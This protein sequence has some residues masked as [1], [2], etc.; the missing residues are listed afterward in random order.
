MTAVTA[1]AW[2]MF[3]VWMFLLLCRGHFWRAGV[4]DDDI[5]PPPPG[6]WPAVTAVI[7]ARDEAD[8]IDATLTSLFAQDYKGSLQIIVVDDQSSDG[9]SDIAR[10]AAAGAGATDR[11]LVLPGAPL[12]EGW[13]GKLWAVNQGI[14]K[15]SR[16]DS[17]PTFIW[18]SDADI[19]YA[20]DTLSSLVAR[21]EAGNLVLTSLMARLRC[22]SLAERWLIPAFIFFFQMLYPFAR[23]NDPRS[24][25]AGAAGGCMLVRREALDKAGGIASIRAALIDDCALGARLKQHGAIWL[26]LTNRALSARPYPRF[27][28]IARMVSRSAYAQ[29]HYSPWLLAG[30]V[31]GL[32]FVYLGPPLLAC[33][34]HDDAAFPALLA[35][36]LMSSMF[37]PILRF[38]RLSPLRAPAL[39]LIA[40]AYL[41][42]T[43]HSAYQHA[44]G[45][46]GMWKGRAQAL[47]REGS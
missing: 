33:V 1:L 11:L 2:L 7:P 3:A 32:A 35:W 17:P 21:A 4:R 8:M 45:R 16:S 6:G 27:S 14:E 5:L 23:V 28:D 44:A 31:I 47:R 43:L 25:M 41:A 36:A 26:G 18:L 22:D 9:T 20:P 19:T 15:A 10:R 37:V 38:Y 40:L 13:T 30:T 34:A 42:F 24:R 46:G 29:L 12:P 39:P